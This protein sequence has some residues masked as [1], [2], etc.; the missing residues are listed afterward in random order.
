MNEY[1]SIYKCI[2]LLEIERD[3]REQDL[4]KSRLLLALG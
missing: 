3:D 2:L 4:P 1:D